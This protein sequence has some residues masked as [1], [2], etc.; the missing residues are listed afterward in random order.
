VSGTPVAVPRID[1][2][3][4]GNPLAPARV[5]YGLTPPVQC[6]VPAWPLLVMPYPCCRHCDT[7]HPIHSQLAPGHA[8]A[9]FWCELESVVTEHEKGTTK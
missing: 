9:C 2:T 8:T 1:W 6:P 4:T 5:G 7:P 3:P